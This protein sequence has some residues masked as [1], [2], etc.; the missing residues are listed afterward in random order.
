MP[1][2]LPPPPVPG[3]PPVPLDLPVPPAASLAPPSLPVTGPAAAVGQDRDVGAVMIEAAAGVVESVGSHELDDL[4][5]PLD[6]AAIARLLGAPSS[7]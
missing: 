1:A 3:E 4:K 2:P 5:R 7:R 6:D